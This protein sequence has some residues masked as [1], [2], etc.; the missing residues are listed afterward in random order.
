MDL[1][2]YTRRSSNDG[3]VGV[4]LFSFLSSRLPISARS[5]AK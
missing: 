2:D 4:A 3:A 5:A 1:V